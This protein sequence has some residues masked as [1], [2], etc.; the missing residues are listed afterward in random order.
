MKKNFIEILK[1]EKAKGN[2]VIFSGIS[3]VVGC[4]GNLVLNA[5]LLKSDELNTDTFPFSKNELVKTSMPMTLCKLETA[6]SKLVKAGFISISKKKDFPAR[7]YYT[8]HK[9]IIKQAVT[10]E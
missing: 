3:S 6:L 5:L 8:V 7:L 2:G 9:D 4:N 10:E 1:E